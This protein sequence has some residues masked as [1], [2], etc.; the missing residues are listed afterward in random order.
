MSSQLMRSYDSEMR[1]D[2]PPEPGQRIE[3]AGGVVRTCG[4]YNTILYSWFDA[5]QAES[6]VAEQAA[7]FTQLR[8]D[9]EWKVYSHDT[10]ANLSSVLASHGFESGELETFMVLP[11]NAVGTDV[12]TPTDVVIRAVASASDLTTYIDVATA[13]SGKQPAWSA[14]IGRRLFDPAADTVAFIA[15][16][17]AEPA[18]AGRLELPPGRSFA[19]IWGGGT[20]P[21]MRNRGVYRALVRERVRLARERGYAYVTVDALETSRPILARLGFSAA[22]TIRAWVLPG[23]G[24]A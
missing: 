24:A 2:P 7:Y 15:Y 1:V 12:E 13:A 6:V 23:T 5:A 11:L 18:A 21:S 10:P 20:V 19:S 9:V 3:R 22:A 16:V 4:S 8:E 17:G 14:E